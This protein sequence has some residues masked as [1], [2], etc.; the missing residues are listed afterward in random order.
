MSFSTFDIDLRPFYLKES[1]VI[2]E[3]LHDTDSFEYENMPPLVNFPTP[4]Y[5]SHTQPPF[6]YQYVGDQ[7]KILQVLGTPLSNSISHNEP[8]N[9]TDHWDQKQVASEE[10]S[11]NNSIKAENIPNVSKNKIDT[12]ISDVISDIPVI[13][14]HKDNN[15]DQMNTETKN[16]VEPM[17]EIDREPISVNMKKVNTLDETA[18]TACIHTSQ[19]ENDC[20][21][22][23][24]EAS[25]GT[26][27]NSPISKK[28][29]LKGK[30]GKCKA[31]LPPVLNTDDLKVVDDK[32][33][34]S[35]NDTDVESIASQESLV[36]IVSKLSYNSIIKSDS[37]DIKDSNLVE[38]NKGRQ[39]SKS[40]ANTPKGSSSGIGK[41]LQ[42][43]SKLAFWQKTDDKPKTDDT[44]SSD[45]ISRR[46]STS[47]R[48]PEEFQSCSDLNDIAE[49]QVVNDTDKLPLEK[50]DRQKNFAEVV[51]VD[52]EI[53]SQDIIDK[54]DALQRLIDAK[55]ENH[56]EYKVI[57]LHEEIPT[58]SKSTDV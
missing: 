21:E 44:P 43:P 25:F 37:K 1:E 55:I 49:T 58:Q 3:E 12:K 40:P 34:E 47:D 13:I 50:V 22:S 53:I 57:S 27:E 23:D 45:D 35:V 19:Y 51:E 5:L 2:I 46:S 8:D 41:L 18:E 20:D 7:V 17:I 33:C 54:S 30:Y 4:I 39:K 11:L 38:E 42:L 29:S 6:I 52:N 16:I 56:P 32:V 10:T 36:D 14:E 31:P 15:N 26:P 24:D 28:K 9:N 48:V